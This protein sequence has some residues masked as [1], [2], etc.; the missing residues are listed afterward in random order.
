MTILQYFA[1]KLIMIKLLRFIQ[2]FPIALFLYTSR[3]YGWDTGF[4]LGGLVAI[5]EFVILI[6]MRIQISRLIA[7]ANLFLVFGGVSFF[8]KIK[9]LLT[10]LSS[11]M[12]AALFISVLIV[13]I[14][15]T[16][17]TKTGA[18]EK[19]QGKNIT[20]FSIFLI[21]FAVCCIGWFFYFQGNIKIAGTVPFVCLIGVKY[22]LQRKILVTS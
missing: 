18:F 3:K 9:Q 21:L 10:L 11:L 8:F 14:V 22:Y 20:K 12:E 16:A 6:A 17:F 4:Q 2:F 7:G 15:T 13:L 1:K 5:I 19:G